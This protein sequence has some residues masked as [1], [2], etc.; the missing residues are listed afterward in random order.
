MKKSKPVTLGHF[1]QLV[2]SAVLALNGKDSYGLKIQDK[3][4]EF[5]EKEVNLGSVYV[6]LERLEMKGLVVTAELSET[7]PE[8]GGKR[9]RIYQIT[10]EGQTVLSESLQASVR[11]YEATESFWE[12]LWKLGRRRV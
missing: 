5:A 2:L 3:T 11:A 7:R 6:T 1:E 4:S 10:P 12:K 9:R 8:P